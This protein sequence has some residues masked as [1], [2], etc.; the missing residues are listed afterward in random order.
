MSMGSGYNKRLAVHTR[1]SDDSRTTKSVSD[2]A[3]PGGN[4]FSTR[5]KAFRNNCT[6]GCIC[7]FIR[8]FHCGGLVSSIGQQV[9]N[10]FILFV[11]LQSFNVQPP[12]QLSDAAL[13]DK[14]IKL[15]M[16]TPLASSIQPASALDLL[17]AYGWKALW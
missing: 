12:L 4:C 11:Q 5:R 2:T 8:S 6:Y 16:S 1:E 9:L 13:S 14:Y 3:P 10:P 17:A 15:F 7:V